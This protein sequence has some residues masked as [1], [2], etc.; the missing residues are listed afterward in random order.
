MA[1]EKLEKA[2]F[3]EGLKKFITK[4][5]NYLSLI[6]NATHRYHSW[7]FKKFSHPQE[8]EKLLNFQADQYQ[9]QCNLV[10]NPVFS[11]ESRMFDEVTQNKAKK[12]L[13]VL[14]IDD[15]IL[16]SFHDPQV[17]VEEKAWQHTVFKPL[18]YPINMKNG[19][20]H[21]LVCLLNPVLLSCLVEMAYQHFA[22]VA[23]CTNGAWEEASIKKMLQQELTVSTKTKETLDSMLFIGP[24]L[25]EKAEPPRVPGI[26]SKKACNPSK[27]QRLAQ[28]SETFPQLSQIVLFDDQE[29]SLSK[30]S[31]NQVGVLCRAFDE[32]DYCSY[33][34]VVEAMTSLAKVPTYHVNQHIPLSFRPVPTA[35]SSDKKPPAIHWACQ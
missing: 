35:D 24:D 34:L 14:D 6:G 3:D 15:T 31:D 27:L 22:G 7:V 32:R 29:S 13:L 20:E 12:I 5:G 19:T 17:I 1:E 28:L 8:L 23:I 18:L 9:K 33:E 25:L 11:M 26:F 30:S 21:S 10:L 4:A 16:H 2:A